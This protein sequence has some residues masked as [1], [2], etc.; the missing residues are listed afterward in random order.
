MN[1]IW[2]DMKHAPHVDIDSQVKVMYSFFKLNKRKTILT[3]NKITNSFFYQIKTSH[4]FDTDREC[5]TFSCYINKDINKITK[6]APPWFMPPIEIY[7]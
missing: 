7:L 1:H 5:I 4:L 6:L 3:L 2:N